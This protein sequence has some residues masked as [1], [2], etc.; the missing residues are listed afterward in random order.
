MITRFLGRSAS[1][2]RVAIEAEYGKP[3]PNAFWDDMNARHERRYHAGVAAMPGVLT[4]VRALHTIGRAQ[5]VA[6]SSNHR[7]LDLVLGNSGLRRFFSPHIFS[8]TQVKN[9]KPAPDIFLFAAQQMGVAPARCAVIE[10]SPAGVQAGMAAGMTVFG[11]QSTAYADLAP[12]GAR[13]FTQMEAL[14]A[15]L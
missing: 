3:I 6:S 2:N 11:Y 7:H 9:G 15:S 13:V 5:C 1:A 12:H 8:A 4:L 14:G 10:D